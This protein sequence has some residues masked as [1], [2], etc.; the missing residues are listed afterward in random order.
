[1]K[2]LILRNDIY[3]RK[4]REIDKVF[5]N[6]ESNLKKDIPHFIAYAPLTEWLKSQTSNLIKP[7]LREYADL[8]EIVNRLKTDL[9]VV[10]DNRLATDNYKENLKINYI[11][12]I[13]NHVGDLKLEIAAQLIKEE[14]FPIEIYEEYYLY[15]KNSTPKQFN[16]VMGEFWGDVGK[17]ALKGAGVGATA[18]AAAG[19]AGGISALPAALT[20]LATGGLVGGVYGGGKHLLNKVWQWYKDHSNYVKTKDDALSVLKRLQHHSHKA[21]IT[22]ERYHQAINDL[23][24][25]LS[26]KEKITPVYPTPEEQ[27]TINRATGDI[28]MG[29]PGPKTW[30]QWS[31]LSKPSA[32]PAAGVKPEPKPV[33]ITPKTEEKPEE[34]EIEYPYPQFKNV[35]DIAL[36]IDGGEGKGKEGNFSK[37]IGGRFKEI[38]DE[39]TKN[40]ILLLGKTVYELGKDNIEEW[41]KIGVPTINAKIAEIHD[42][43]ISELD[44]YRFAKYAETYAKSVLFNKLNRAGVLKTKLGLGGIFHGA[45]KPAPT[46]AEVKPEVPPVAPTPAEVKP[47]V[48]PVEAKPIEPETPTT[49][50]LTT[51]KPEPMPEAQPKPEKV[52]LPKVNTDDL[53]EFER[54]IF[55]RMQK[56]ELHERL[57]QLFPPS[58]T[59][60]A[61]K[62]EGTPLEK[63]LLDGKFG[64]PGSKQRIAI[65]ASLRKGFGKDKINDES[66]LTESVVHKFKR[67]LKEQNRPVVITYRAKSL[68]VDERI[69]LYKESLR[70]N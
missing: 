15:F 37:L 53:S 59:S 17:A 63:M 52:E 22:D 20:G 57:H 45:R 61:Y 70:R 19:A 7:S 2:W 25:H 42:K 33:E 46:P 49:A 18:G 56:D 5:E 9:L 64:K 35:V 16:E 54:D 43:E 65:I 66:D 36:K 55:E 27:L 58:L 21:G 26:G 39:K 1:M 51:A 3:T 28:P 11:R 62:L 31:K 47:E 23:V 10:E 68:P 69:K 24:D 12:M 60:V 13:H 50:P 30:D 6:I 40:L 67:L 44:K 8:T 4:L 41:K 34:P 32:E 38:K 29:E 48:P 14:N